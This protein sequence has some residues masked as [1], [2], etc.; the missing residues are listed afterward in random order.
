LPL[1]GHHHLAAGPSDAAGDPWSVPPS[2]RYLE[3]LWQG[4]SYE[5]RSQLPLRGREQGELPRIAE[6]LFALVPA[7]FEVTEW[8]LLHQ[9]VDE[10]EVE[11]LIARDILPEASS[12]NPAAEIINKCWQE[13]TLS[14]ICRGGGGTEE[15][16]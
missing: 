8:K 1:Q 16:A 3:I 7:I 14:I 10:E 15:N 6:D 9:D 13:T 5:D 4:S 2:P 12:N 11:M